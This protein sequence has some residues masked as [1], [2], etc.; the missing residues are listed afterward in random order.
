MHLSHKT[1]FWVGGYKK[2]SGEDKLWLDCAPISEYALEMALES[3]E[4]VEDF[5]HRFILLNTVLTYD[6]WWMNLQEEV[7]GA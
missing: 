7:R 6:L 1:G 3:S 4:T 2:T 5:D